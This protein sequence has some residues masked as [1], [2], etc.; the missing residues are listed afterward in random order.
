[1]TYRL[2]AHMR[3]F[4]LWAAVGCTLAGLLSMFVPDSGGSVLYLVGLPL[5]CLLLFF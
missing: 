3:R 5:L 1:M 2:L 4:I